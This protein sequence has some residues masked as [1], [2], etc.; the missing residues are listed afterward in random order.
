[1]MTYQCVDM[2]S[3][4]LFFSDALMSASWCW[5]WWI[6]W[7]IT[8]GR[9]WN[10]TLC[11][12]SGISHLSPSL[13]LSDVW[14]GI[15]GNVKKE[16]IWPWRSHAILR[17]SRLGLVLILAEIMNTNVLQMVEKL[18]KMWLSK[19]DWIGNKF[20]VTNRELPGLQ[21]MLNI[22]IKIESVNFC[23]SI[24]SLAFQRQ[25]EKLKF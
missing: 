10:V 5:H 24:S 21:I 12:V 15:C 6:Y 18:R 9:L 25:L 22:T 19:T 1:M 3:E 17:F 23:Y 2:T 7:Q 8:A 14:Y 11:W 16:K 4:P 13:P 20:V